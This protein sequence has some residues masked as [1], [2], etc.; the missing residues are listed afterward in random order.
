MLAGASRFCKAI[1]KIIIIIMKFSTFGSIPQI[2]DV[3]AQEK[4]FARRIKV[5]SKK[6][7]SFRGGILLGSNYSG[8][9]GGIRVNLKEFFAR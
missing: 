5:T 4:P 9:D 3:N 2:L 6:E 7:Q 8:K 1:D